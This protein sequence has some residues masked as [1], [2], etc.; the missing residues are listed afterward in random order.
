MDEDARSG[1]E[2]R[3]MR[4]WHGLE[5]VA[6]DYGRYVEL[7]DSDPSAFGGGHYVFY[8]LDDAEHRFAI[9]EQ[10]ADEESEEEQI[11]TSWTWRDES[12]RTRP[13]GGGYWHAHGNGEVASE[14]LEQLLDRARQW[15]Q[16]A[17]TTA[18]RDDAASAF[19]PHGPA[20]IPRGTE[21]SL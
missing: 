8:R 14:D 11:P 4:L 15:A 9:E 2:D 10:Y 3:M 17:R 21:R 12:L 5:Q 6:Q 20:P 18:R 1:F 13:T 7:T 19:A 16:Q